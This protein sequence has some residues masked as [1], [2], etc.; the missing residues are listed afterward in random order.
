MKLRHALRDSADAP[1]C[2]ETIPR[3]G[4]RFIAALE[5]SES[6]LGS[7]NQRIAALTN[8][9]EEIVE[10]SDNLGAFQPQEDQ[11]CRIPPAFSQSHRQWF[12]RPSQ[13]GPPMVFVGAARSSGRS[14]LRR[15][16][17][18][19]LGLEYPY[20]TMWLAVALSAR[21]GKLGPSLKTLLAGAIGIYNFLLL[22]D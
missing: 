12:L 20:H 2:I 3:I 11:A 5:V 8:D 9:R 1:R 13:E 18:P 21:H 14:L 22:R 17:D 19:L 10:H 16:L 7:M 4:Y 15:A 6:S